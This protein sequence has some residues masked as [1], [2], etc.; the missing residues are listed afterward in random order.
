[1]VDTC[2]DASTCLDCTAES[3]CGYCASSGECVSGNLMGPA[4]GT[5]ADWD[6][7]STQC[8]CAPLAATCTMDSM[9]CGDLSCRR[10]ATFGVRCC[11]ES[12][13]T[14]A[15][16]ADCCGYMDCVSGRCTCR[17]AGRGC[18]DNRDCCSNTCTAGRCA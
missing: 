7:T 14:C 16:G 12:M 18:L 4:T 3:G 5:C 8:M 2:S 11:V 17:A 15:S 10:G 13:A 6:Y 1:M 9:C